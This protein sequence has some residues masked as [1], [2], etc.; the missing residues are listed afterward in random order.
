MADDTTSGGP[1]PRVARP[2]RNQ[3][4]LLA[5]DLESLIPA[6]HPVRA[7]WE[8]V[9]GLDLSALYA[10]IAAVE[11][12]PGRPASDPAVLFALWLFAT[13]NGVGSARQLDR[14]TREHDAYRWLRGGVPVDYHLLADFRVAH[15]EVL[16]EQ[17]VAS[18]AVLMESGLVTLKEVAQD[19][20]RV[21]ASAGAGS[22]RKEE[23]LT[24]AL[25]KAQEQVQALREQLESDPGAGTRRERAAQ[26]RAAR[27][28]EERVAA[29]LKR[30]PELRA[31]KR[32]SKEY[33]AAEA[34]AAETDGTNSGNGGEGG[35]AP[36]DGG[37][38]A[39]PENPSGGS[40]AAGASQQGAGAEDSGATT[41]GQSEP[42][43]AVKPRGRGLDLSQ[44]R[45]STTDAE[46][47]VM[48]LAD[49]GFRPA[50]NVQNCVDTATGLVVGVEV[51]SVGRDGPHLLDM[52]NRVEAAYGVRPERVLADGDYSMRENIA[53]TAAKGITQYSPPPKPKTADR[54]RYE[55]RRDDPKVV[56]DWRVRMGTSEA[57]AI[58]RRRCS[59]VE[60]VNAQY[61]NHG[62]Q[63]VN[64]RGKRKVKAVSLWHAISVNMQVT[65]RITA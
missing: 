38:S 32:G 58:Y 63:Q 27:E 24:E 25:T 30:I 51:S 28:R 35:A 5:R 42:V 37:T 48:K 22:Y 18:V 16:E 33:R 21:R 41:A 3:V 34:R 61:R 15:P 7:V 56:A 49:N 10:K 8:F 12:A 39:P 55:P 45:A 50:F 19:G 2:V 64:V 40:G 11:G 53:G 4:E 36:A 14:L 57:A 47:E 44:V 23:G 1:A 65:W 54:G 6:E 62:L 59:T 17:L 60:W 29:A 26:A 52:L 43:Q 31:R 46:A 20:M 9:C 13:I